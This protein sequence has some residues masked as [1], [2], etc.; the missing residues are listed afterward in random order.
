M[1]KT[2][3]IL[4]ILIA[5]SALYPA[6]AKPRD[7]SV[8]SN[9]KTT[10]VRMP[11]YKGTKLEYFLR[12]RSTTIRGKL[13]D[14]VWPMVDMIRSG[15]SVEDIAAADSNVDVY[16]LDS[17]L[18]TVLKY[19]AERAYSDGVVVSEEAT[20][21]QYHDTAFGTGK[22]F[23]RSPMVD[24]NAVGFSVNQKDKFIKFNSNVEIVL[25]N[26]G[27]NSAILAGKESANKKSDNKKDKISVTRAYSNEMTVD[28]NRKVIT[29][30]GNVRVFSEEGTVTSQK[31]EIEYG[32]SKT[33]NEKTDGKNSG[34]ADRSRSN[35]PKLA[36]FIGNVHAVR[37]LTAED[38]AKGEQY[39]D[40]DLMVYDI[41]DKVLVMTGKRSRIVQGRDYGEAE[42]IKVQSSDKEQAVFFSGK[43]VF[44]SHSK[45]KP[46]AQP[47]R[48]TS[49]YAD[50]VQKKN[51][52][53][54]MGDVYINSPEDKTEL[55][56]D[57]VTVEMAE[58]KDKKTAGKADSNDSP[59]SGQNI[60]R[61]VAFGNVRID[62][63]GE[64]GKSAARGGRMTYIKAEEK[65]IMEM[66]PE[67]HSNDDILRGG[68]M[69]YYKN[70]ER[71]M[72]TEGSH[73][74]LSGKTVGENNSGMGLGK[75]KPSSSSP[76]TVE[77]KESDLNFGS[78]LLAFKKDVKVRGRGMQLD[79]DLLDITLEDAAK[80]RDNAEKVSAGSALGKKKKP[81][82]AL[83]TGNVHAEDASGIMD[84]GVLDA[85]FGETVTP[86]KREI[87]KVFVSG[88]VRLR[89]KVKEEP[90]QEKEKKPEQELT[91]P[92]LL[93]ESKTGIT[94]L[95]ADRGE[96]DLIKHTADFYEDITLYDDKVMLECD[97][98]Q[99][100][101]KPTRD[102]I[103]APEKYRA[104]DE[105]PDR[106]ALGEGMELERVMAHDKVV[107]TRTVSPDEVQKARGDHAC[108]EVKDRKVFLTCDPP[109][110]P[111][112]V[113][114]QGGLI[115][116]SVVVDLDN[117][118]IFVE[119]GDALNRR[120]K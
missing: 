93:G 51:T 106:L 90:K 119:N 53:R 35:K 108:Y 85:L 63:K 19:W 59:L 71:M 105:F 43:C 113:T 81:V 60:S 62:Q 120:K 65:L 46:D 2:G 7:L 115:G 37:K 31:L 56:A 79:S 70:S 110:Q 80:T 69:T 38:A 39:A 99:F 111:R 94:N 95:D 103:E 88:K 29:L 117:Q 17:T 32:S 18:E 100:F 86:G 75:A 28:D 58:G 107:M 3:K 73:I 41:R 4:L 118:Q 27:G 82:R 67:L 101:A 34:L 84:S 26:R 54:L 92:T 89:N 42:R 10:A 15:V 48:V 66:Q 102:V 57:R 11:Y 13:V 25:R 83:A 91:G 78:N 30:I 116:D 24:I 104:R 50:W 68:L 36:R 114:S 112:A 20:F 8:F 52:V 49:N 6:F 87:E 74:T 47:T 5:V 21:D 40:A 12:G 76:V 16:P 98:L 55:R 33:E 14:V 45:E 44:I 109:G 64:S 22:V 1:K 23:L 61:A 77:S 9:V 72:V 97:H 96:L